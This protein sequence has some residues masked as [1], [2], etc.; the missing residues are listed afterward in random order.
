MHD[1]TLPRHPL[2]GLS[3]VGWRNARPGETGPQPIWPVLGGAPDD[4]GEMDDADGT[5]DGGGDTEPDG[6][7]GRE[8]AD[9]PLGEAGTKALTAEKERRKAEAERRRKAEAERDE[10]R[11]QI[12]A[13]QQGDGGPTPEQI[14]REA[15]T[16]ATARANDRIVRSEI[17]AAAAGKLADPKDALRF[18]DLTRFEVD[19][20]GQVDEDAIT[21]ALDDLL[22]SKPYLAAATTAKPRFEGTGDGGARK[23]AV[24]PRQ[25]TEA[26]IKKMT[27]EQIDEA[28]RKGQLRDY[29]G[30]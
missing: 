12:E 24:G 22:Q 5:S 26:D 18:L 19:N 30:S 14:R 16:A 28:H 29:M 1:S 13:S 11:R 10:L 27:P 3:A 2:T 17:R 20:D 21:E 15:D 25:L 9:E 8:P 6:D 7:I 23:A 4:E